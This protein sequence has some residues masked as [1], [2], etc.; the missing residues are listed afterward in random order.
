[1]ALV[2]NTSW[3]AIASEVQILYLPPT[4]AK[5]TAGKPEDLVRGVRRSFN[6]GGLLLL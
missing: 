3:Q 4:F 1:M 2:S 6:E 5:A